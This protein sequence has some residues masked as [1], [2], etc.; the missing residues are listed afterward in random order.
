MKEKTK[1]LFSRIKLI[2]LVLF[3][4]GL[5]LRANFL[6]IESFAGKISLTSVR[7]ILFALIIFSIPSLISVIKENFRN[8]LIVLCALASALILMILSS[9][10]SPFPQIEPQ[11]RPLVV[12][13][14]YFLFFFTMQQNDVMKRWGKGLIL[15]SVCYFIVNIVNLITHTSEGLGTIVED[16]LFWPGKNLFALFAVLGIFLIL[17]EAFRAKT[18][19]SRAFFFLCSGLG[20]ANIAFA[21][22]RAAL[23]AFAG[24]MLVF[25]FF[26]KGRQRKASLLLLGLLLLSSF[27]L[28]GIRTRLQ[29]AFQA[30]DYNTQERIAIWK[31]T[32][33]IIQD[34]PLLGVGAG[35][36]SEVFFKE[37]SN[38]RFERKEEKR[39][40][41]HSH[42]LFLQLS[43]ESGIPAAVLLTCVYL[44]I[45]LTHAIR[46]IRGKSPSAGLTCSLLAFSMYTLFDTTYNA[47]F[48]HASMFHINLIVL[49]LLARLLIS[50]QVPVHDVSHSRHALSD[51]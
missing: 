19:R 44:F 42:N 4:A 31:G 36:F 22:S 48:T 32:L 25:L 3:L 10:F 15:F 16:Y 28:P 1:V 34:H 45:V 2:I 21:Y 23:I 40:N 20:L 9:S 39:K 41:Y 6:H 27:L 35:R 50:H 5:F 18:A 7:N 43:A 38:F 46:I 37:Y 29:D 14:A 33:Q 17:S 49:I 30:K 12:L 13:T 8:H 11:G 47:H 26:Q 51:L 24:G